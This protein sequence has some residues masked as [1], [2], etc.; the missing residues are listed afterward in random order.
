MNK[1]LLKAIATLAVLVVL[2][3][4]TR[5]WMGAGVD[6]PADR[7]PTVSTIP[8]AAPRHR[9]VP[10][11]GTLKGARPGAVEP[12]RE[13]TSRRVR[14]GVGA[15][16]V[17]PDGS[18]GGCGRRRQEIRLLDARTA[19]SAWTARRRADVPVGVRVATAG[20]C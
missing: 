4:V 13:V 7:G 19:R 6:A 10:A 5:A 11:A 2:G 14:R 9:V 3:I 16:A 1:P 12:Q 8:E 17:S 15:L 20:G 18:A